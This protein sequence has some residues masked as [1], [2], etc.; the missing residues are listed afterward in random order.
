M[1]ARLLCVSCNSTLGSELIGN[2]KSNATIRLI[3]EDLKNELPALYSRLMDKTTFVGKAPDGSKIRVSQTRKGRK[4]L[5]SK[6][7]DGS[8][9]QDTKEASKTLENILVKDKVFPD[10]IEKLKKVFSELEEDVLLNV[11]DNFTFEKK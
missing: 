9:I 4:V 5:S 10:E 11:S 1:Q 7:M 2:L 6:G 3:M 8:I